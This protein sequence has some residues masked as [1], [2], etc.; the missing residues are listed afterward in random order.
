MSNG[1]VERF[2]EPVMS[3]AEAPRGLKSTLQNRRGTQRFRRSFVG[4]HI[5][6]K[7]TR[8]NSLLFATGKH[9]DPDLDQ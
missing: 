3:G 8:Q 9:S 2:I 6:R 7:E 4:L 5:K 1:F